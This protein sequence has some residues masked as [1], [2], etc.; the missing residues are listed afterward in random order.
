MIYLTFAYY[1]LL[2]MR[3]YF[4]IFY[5]FFKIGAFTVGGGYAMIQ[6]IEREVVERKKWMDKEEF[7]EMLAIAQTAPGPIA[8]NTAVFT[9]YKLRK[10]RGSLAST[11]GAILPSFVI[12][13]FIAIFFSAAMKDNAVIERIFKGIRPVVVALIAIPAFNM[14]VK[15][16]LKIKPLAITLT[17]ALLICLLN[18]SP[19]WILIAAGLIGLWGGINN[20]KNKKL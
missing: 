2:D 20:D 9:G 19:I 10:W 5:S 14:I 7:V 1:N 4:E 15:A 16:G 8:I 3:I 17:A 6:L 11:L 18:I 12:I 13:L